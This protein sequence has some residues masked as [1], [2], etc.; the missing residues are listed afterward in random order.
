MNLSYRLYLLLISL[1]LS[2]LLLAACQSTPAPTPEATPT[3]DV[4]PS[5]TPAAL[6]LDPGTLRILYWQAPTLLNPHLTSATKDWEAARL[7]YEPLASFDKDG[8]L[9]PFLAAEIPSLENGGLAEDGRSVTWRLKEGVQWSDGTPFTAND[10]RFTYEYITDPDV[11]SNSAGSYANVAGVNVI[12]ELTVQVTFTDVT[13]A[14]AQPFVGLSGVILPEHIFADYKGGN[15][16]SAPAN[17]APIGTGPFQVLEFAAEDIIIIGNNVV[18]TVKIEY[19]ANPLYHEPDRPFFQR[20]ELRGGGDAEVAARAVLQEGAVDYAWNVQVDAEV[21]NELEALGRGRLVDG[22]IPSVERLFLN[23]SDPNEP[24]EAAE[25]SSLQYPHPFLSDLRVRQAIALAIDREAIN[26]VYGISGQPTSNI[27]VARPTFAIDGGV[28][29]SYNL[30]QARA[31]LDEA[32]W[33]DSD[34]DGVRDQNGREMRIVI[35]TTVNPLRERILGII[36]DSLAE[37]GIDAEIKIIDASIFGRREATNIN[38]V[39]H[40]YAD[41]QLLAWGSFTPDP[42][43]YLSFWTC[44]QVPQMNNGWTGVNFERYCDDTYETLYQTST[45]TIDPDERRAL[46]QDMVTML[47]EE[48]VT[49]PLIQRSFVSAANNNLSGVDL[50]PWDSDVWNIKDW[51]RETP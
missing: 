21:L 44:G 14:W 12:D 20:V 1:S 23:H 4:T 40:F 33:V 13:P 37:I 3:A 32:G 22:P 15:A 7:V 5:P 51:R 38:S 39:F 18:E 45:T 43:Q 24:T 34:G 28:P 49:I 42:G 30:A 27:M 46:V 19:E 25:F 2:L 47:T 41:M 31:L 16:R 26:A 29:D 10:V 8:N 48:V 9:V 36:Q 11:A 17:L 6:N 35:Q 50:T